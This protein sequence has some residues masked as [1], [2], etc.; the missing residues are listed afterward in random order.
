MM[1]LFA[2]FA[3]MGFRWQRQQKK[4]ME[5]ERA[6]TAAMANELAYKINHPLQA[7]TNQLYRAGEGDSKLAH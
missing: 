2:D 1:R 7:L 3:A 4:L 5:K 6:A